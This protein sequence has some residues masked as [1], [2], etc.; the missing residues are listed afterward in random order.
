MKIL[1]RH[2]RRNYLNR[3]SRGKLSTN[4]LKRKSTNNRTEASVSNRQKLGQ[5]Y[6][7]SRR[8]KPRRGLNSPT[9]LTPYR[10][11]PRWYPRHWPVR[12][13]PGTADT[14]SLSLYR[15]G[16]RS[17]IM[18]QAFLSSCTPLRSTRNSTKTPRGGVAQFNKP[19][20]PGQSV[21]P[22]VYQVYTTRPRRNYVR[23]QSSAPTRY[24]S[25]RMQRVHLRRC[26]LLPGQITDS[27]AIRASVR[28]RLRATRPG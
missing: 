27:S 1:L 28:T 24:S 5:E 11:L 6:I 2:K 7:P 25:N 17:S 23:L 12:A 15:S 16:H 20:P 4:S 21:Q 26:R 10:P 13:P 3:T 14:I 18:D 9:R 22:G 8:L 19:L